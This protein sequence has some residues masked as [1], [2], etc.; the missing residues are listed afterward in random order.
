MRVWVVPDR[1]LAQ[2]VLNTAALSITNRNRPDRHSEPHDHSSLP[3][4]PSS[5]SRLVNRLKIATYRLTVAMM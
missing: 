4:K 3:M 2:D 5:W 1:H